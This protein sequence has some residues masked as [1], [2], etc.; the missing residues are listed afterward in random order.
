[1][2]KTW[3]LAM[4]KLLT[5]EVV[6]TP[7]VT[8]MLISGRITQQYF[9]FFTETIFA[10]MSTWTQPRVLEVCPA[11]VRT[12]LKGLD[13]VSAKG[14]KAIDLSEIVH[15]VT[16]QGNETNTSVCQTIS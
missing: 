5:G 14:I 10:P 4:L 15:K 2:C 1:M 3:H 16:D 12:S 8:P 6:K 9:Q 7:N 11:S 13:N